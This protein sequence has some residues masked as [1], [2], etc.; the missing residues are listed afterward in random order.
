[1][2][3]KWTEPQIQAAI[4]KGKKRSQEDWL[5]TSIFRVGNKRDDQQK[6]AEALDIRRLMAIV[7]KREP[8]L[9]F[10]NKEDINS[11]AYKIS[12]NVASKERL[13]QKTEPPLNR[14]EVPRFFAAG[15]LSSIRHLKL[16]SDQD[17]MIGW[18]ELKHQRCLSTARLEWDVILGALQV[19]DETGKIGLDSSIDKHVDKQAK[20]MILSISEQM[21]CMYKAFEIG[22]D[23]L[24]V[25]YPNFTT[26]KGLFVYFLRERA[27][28]DF[29]HLLN[30]QEIKIYADNA[31]IQKIKYIVQFVLTLS[32][33]LSG[34]L[35][36]NLREILGRHALYKD[37]LD[38][39]Q[40]DSKALYNRSP[41]Q[42]EYAE[43]LIF[44]IKIL[45]KSS[46]P[47]VRKAAWEL[48]KKSLSCFIVAQRL[49]RHEINNKTK[50]NRPDE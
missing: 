23:D 18:D 34:I 10:D 3:Y 25:H 39:I 37:S 11:E 20:A 27:R 46:N 9:A 22:W 19:L 16:P 33:K 6:K 30:P 45:S 2:T 41:W 4:K 8:T 21:A 26:H 42:K 43:R 40:K 48:I 5:G 14:I 50:S 36:Q 13:L 24:K 31:R 44:I 49:I 47:E 35:P 29:E 32:E 17:L 28:A 38:R 1:M 7:V 15:L 12:F